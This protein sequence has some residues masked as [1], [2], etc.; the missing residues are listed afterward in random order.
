MPYRY[1]Y[2]VKNSLEKSY[3]GEV[4]ERGGYLVVKV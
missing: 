1:C 3:Y 2:E 4:L